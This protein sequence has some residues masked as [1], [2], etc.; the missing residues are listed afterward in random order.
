MPISVTEHPERREVLVVVAGETSMKDMKNFIIS[1]RGGEQRGF[2]FL[3]DVSAATASL[4]GDEMRQLAAYAADEARKAP[5]GPVAFISTDPY[6]YGIC[7]MY[8]SY[9]AAEGRKSVGVFRTLTD[10]QTWLA[11]LKH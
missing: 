9:S 7:R 11:G 8:Q 6:A 2:A 10:A 1:R 5:M 4:S 3:F